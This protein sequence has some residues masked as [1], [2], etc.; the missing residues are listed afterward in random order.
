MR[1]RKSRIAIYRD[2]EVPFRTIKMP[3]RSL[4]PWRAWLED[5]ELVREFHSEGAYPVDKPVSLGTF[6][7]VTKRM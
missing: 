7:T 3:G 5:G 2:G 6:E 1:S 4:A